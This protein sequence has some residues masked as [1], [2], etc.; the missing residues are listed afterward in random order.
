[1]ADLAAVIERRR[2]SN[3]KAVRKFREKK[4]ALSV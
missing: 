1:V 3:L 4:K 2:E